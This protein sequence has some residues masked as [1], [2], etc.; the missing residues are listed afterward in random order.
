MNTFCKT[1]SSPLKLPEPDSPTLHPT[2]SLHDLICFLVD[3][4]ASLLALT[5]GIDFSKSGVFFFVLIDS[6]L[7]CLSPNAASVVV[8]QNGI[9]FDSQPLTGN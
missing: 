6:R 1:V 3:L 7:V 8:E 5:L 9:I 4:S 2:T